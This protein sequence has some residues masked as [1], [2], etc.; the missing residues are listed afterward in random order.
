MPRSPAPSLPTHPANAMPSLLKSCS[1]HCKD[2]KEELATNLIE[3]S[4]CTLDIG[5]DE[6]SRAR[7][8]DCRGEENVPPPD[9]VSQ[10]RISLS[11][12]SV[13]AAGVESRDVRARARAA[14]IRR[15]V[16]RALQGDL[17]A[18]EFWA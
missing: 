16:E 10:T 13:D 14:R 17:V 2:T 6:E 3:H 1:F 18:E 8:R 9:D 5:S 4:T 11:S 7:E 12:S 15:E